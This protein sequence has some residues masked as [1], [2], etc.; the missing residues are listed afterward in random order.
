[1]NCIFPATPTPRRNASRGPRVV[2]RPPAAATDLR[3][4]RARRASVTVAASGRGD[5]HN[6]EPGLGREPPPSPHHEPEERIPSPAWGRG[7]GRTIGFICAAVDADLGFPRGKRRLFES[8]RP[9]SPWITVVP[10]AV[11][12]GFLNRPVSPLCR[13]V[14]FPREYGAGVL[15]IAASANHGTHSLHQLSQLGR[16]ERAGRPQD[17]RLMNGDE[18]VRKSHARP[19]D[20]TA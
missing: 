20:A 10:L 13:P 16:R 4:P 7:R 5:L 18:P 3:F 14:V 12:E 1:M 6:R 17:D 2:R 8:S 15:H 19:I 11:G 9:D